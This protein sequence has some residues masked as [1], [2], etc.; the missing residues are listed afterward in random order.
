MMN[1]YERLGLQ[2]NAISKAIQKAYYQKA[3]EIHPDHNPSPQATSWMQQL[4]EAYETLID[5]DLRKAYDQT[6]PEETVSVNKRIGPSYGIR[7]SQTKQYSI[8]KAI[9][10][11]LGM[12]CI[13][14]LLYYIVAFPFG[15]STL[16]F[17][18]FYPIEYFWFGLLHG[19]WHSILIILLSLG[20]MLL[21]R[22]ERARSWM[23]HASSAFAIA[24]VFFFA[25]E[26]ARY[27]HVNDLVASSEERTLI[28]AAENHTF[29]EKFGLEVSKI[30]YQPKKSR[31]YIDEVGMV[32]GKHYFFTLELDGHGTKIGNGVHERV[33]WIN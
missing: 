11:A 18:L 8:P 28:H 14:A 12:M 3:K 27:G 19:A 32:D 23:H 30:R 17:S 20:V 4:T 2:R 31:I 15:L 5:E 16:G 22:N 25:I 1:H 24:V 9:G 10:A 6:L 26:F 7:P 29:R 21:Y 13:F 33:D